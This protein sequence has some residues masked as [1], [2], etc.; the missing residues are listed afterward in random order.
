MA[1]RRLR[2]RT[3]QQ[4]RKQHFAR[5]KVPTYV[6]F[7]IMLL[8]ATGLLCLLIYAAFVGVGKRHGATTSGFMH[9]L[10]DDMKCI[11]V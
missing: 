6:Y 3:I 7:L 4:E 11:P 1:L 2:E 9:C 10:P 5:D 8:L